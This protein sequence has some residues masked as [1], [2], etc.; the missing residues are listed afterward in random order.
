M[1]H[2]A[3]SEQEGT[4]IVKVPYGEYQIDGFE[5]DINSANSILAGKLNH[6][7]DAHSSEKFQVS[8]ESKGRGLIFRFIEPIEKKLLKNKYSINEDI[9]LNWHPYPGATEYKI[10]IY[11]KADPHR[12]TNDA[13]LN[14]LKSLVSLARRLS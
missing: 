2:W 4:Y 5:L 12:Y 10:Q 13:I 1:S 9:I 8:E 14:G 6:P 7:Q 11:E 3:T